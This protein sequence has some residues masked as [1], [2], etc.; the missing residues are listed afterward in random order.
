VYE[1]NSL[2]LPFAKNNIFSNAVDEDEHIDEQE[3][4]LAMT[5]TLQLRSVRSNVALLESHVGEE[6]WDAAKIFCAHLC[7]ST[8][9]ERTAMNDAT[10][11]AR[12]DVTARTI[13]CA[14][15]LKNKKVLELGAGIGCLGMYVATLG[16]SEVL[17]TDYDDEVLA[18]LRFN[19]R[20]NVTHMGANIDAGEDGVVER[21]LATRNAFG[22]CTL[23][24]ASL[25]WRHLTDDDETMSSSSGIRL[26]DEKA[27]EDQTQSDHDE[28]SMKYHGNAYMYNPDIV[29]GSA[30]VYS[31]EGAMWCADTINYFLSERG[32]KEAWVLQ[33]PERPGFDRCLMRL[34][35][36]WG[37]EYEKYNID[38]DVFQLAVNSV[39]VTGGGKFA[40]DVDDFALFII[41]KG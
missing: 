34:E 17:C 24:W 2:V 35:Q 10:T 1:W 33:M 11:C 40:S 5:T 7:L 26:Q 41:R 32:A 6:L 22:H 8:H 9:D 29:I 37:L 25:D 14:S 27:T 12:T 15:R 20:H 13:A 36:K 19:L 30:L 16:A 38:D 18:N 21:H 3:G 28:D 39:G 4:A 31:A 23:Q